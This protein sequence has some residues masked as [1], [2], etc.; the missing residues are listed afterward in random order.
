MNQTIWILLLL[1][2]ELN[3]VA[4]YPCNLQQRKITKSTIV[5]VTFQVIFIDQIVKN[6]RL[7][8]NFLTSILAGA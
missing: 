5:L 2:I 1:L 4:D 6:I 8:Y 3:T 7:V